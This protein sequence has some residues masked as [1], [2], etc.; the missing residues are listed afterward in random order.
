VIY[1]LIALVFSAF[2]V[3]IGSVLLVRRYR[4][5]PSLHHWK[6]S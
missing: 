1:A 3:V 6:S 5:S 4:A 2:L